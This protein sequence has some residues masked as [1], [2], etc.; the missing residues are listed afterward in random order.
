MIA[1]TTWQSECA[2]LEKRG[3][4]ILLSGA[5]ISV[6][7]MVTYWVDYGFYFLSGPVRWCL[8]IA[9]QSFFIIIIMICLLYLPD[10]PRWLAMRGRHAEVRDVIERLLGIRWMMRVEGCEGGV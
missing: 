1:I 8:P 7:I 9:F 3:S 2:R 6:G 5:L 4:L 10:S